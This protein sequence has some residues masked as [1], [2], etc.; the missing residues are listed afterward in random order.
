MLVL[1]VDPGLTRCGYCC[2]EERGGVQSAL[3]AGV[4]RTSPS[5]APPDRLAEIQKEVSSLIEELRPNAVAVER[6]IFGANA[7]T[8]IRVA[9]A[10]GVV[11]AEAAKAGVM[12]R[13]FPPSEIK[14]AVCGYGRADKQQVTRMVQSLLGLTQPLRPPDVS[15]A[16]AVALCYLAHSRST[17]AAAR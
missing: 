12:V 8:A 15:D 6:L 4:V 9:Q 5:D 2:V 1:G 14:L 10:A 3:A 13:E 11:M 7:R 17:P 16:A